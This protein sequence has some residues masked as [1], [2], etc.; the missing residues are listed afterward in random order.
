MFLRFIKTMVAVATLS[1]G[2]AQAQVE[3]TDNA[4]E[5]IA[6]RLE[7]EMP[8][9][10]GS[11][12][13][14]LMAL[15]IGDIT[16]TGYSMVNNE[17]VFNGVNTAGSISATVNVTTS[18]SFTGSFTAGVQGVFSG[19]AGATI[20]QSASGTFNMSI[21]WSTQMTDDGQL[22]LAYKVGVGAEIREGAFLLP[23]RKEH[24]DA[25]TAPEKPDFSGDYT[26]GDYTTELI[27]WYYEQFYDAVPSGSVSWGDVQVMECDYGYGNDHWDLPS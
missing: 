12:V 19:T 26:P 7:G 15:R 3:I 25:T 2:L 1:L 21:T 10:A 20:G 8:G 6:N 27:F 4:G 11:A 14:Q 22:R 16:Y 13:A 18:G 9:L 17:Y 23:I 24:L 5:Q